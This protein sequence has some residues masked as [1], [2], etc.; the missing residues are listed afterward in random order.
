MSVLL[1]VAC[2]RMV[3]LI[4]HIVVE[5]SMHLVRPGTRMLLEVLRR[6]AMLL[7]LLCRLMALCF[8]LILTQIGMRL[9]RPEPFVIL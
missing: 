3:L 9:V 5:F 1:G 6:R 8:E 7:E 4:T 2:R